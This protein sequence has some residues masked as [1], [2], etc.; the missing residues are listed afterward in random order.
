MVLPDHRVNT[1]LPTPPEGTHQ[2][3]SGAGHD[4]VA[5]MSRSDITLPA[6]AATLNV[7]LAYNI[8]EDYDY[9]FLEVESPAGTWTVLP[10]A[11]IDPDSGTASEVGI[12]G[13]TP[14][15]AYAPASFD[16]SEYAGQTI[17]LRARYVTDGA[18]MGDDPD[19]GWSGILLDDIEVVS[20]TT[21]VFADGAE[22]TPNGWTL[23]GFSSV[24]ATYTADFAHY[25]L[26]ELP[27]LRVL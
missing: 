10:T 19:L 27:D 3:W 23:D 2:W 20:G 11:A 12:D 18:V 1:L 21:T 22:T 24:G 16:L 26:A 15:G 14:G 5:S 6:G 8:E 4:Y 17:G 7:Q 9:A 25:Y 13:S